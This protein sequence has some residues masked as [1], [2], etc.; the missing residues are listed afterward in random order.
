MP[1]SQQN[2]KESTSD[3]KGEIEELKTVLNKKNIELMTIS[4]KVEDYRQEISTKTTLLK[5][6]EDEICQLKENNARLIDI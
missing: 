1:N 3:F 6:Q 5:D 4:R 2:S